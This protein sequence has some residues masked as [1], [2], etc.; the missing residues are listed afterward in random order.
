[1]KITS[2]LKNIELPFK[3]FEIEETHIIHVVGSAY[4][5]VF[6]VIHEDAFDI[7]TGTV[8]YLD[9]EELNKNYGITI[10]ADA[11]RRWG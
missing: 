11:I 3:T 4:A 2:K 9:A 7:V 5:N 8:E 10:T 6:F 1:M